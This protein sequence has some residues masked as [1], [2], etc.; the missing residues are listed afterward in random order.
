M[1]C[2]MEKSLVSIIVPV[3]NTAE[4]VEEC[5][6]SVLSQSYKNIELILVNDGS[7]DGSGEICK[8]YED[9][10]NVHY[11]EKENA[12]VVEA[13]K[14]GL[15]EAH[16]EWIMFVD[17]DDYILKNCVDELYALTDDVD[18]VVGCNTN[19]EKLKDAPKY[20]KRE[21]YLYALYCRKVPFAP[22][23]KLI[24][25]E[26]FDHC[27]MTFVYKVP[28]EEDYIMNLALARVNKK[29]VAVWKKPVYFY[30]E[31]RESATHSFS[32]ELDYCYNLCH[33]IESILGGHM[34]EKDLNH[35]KILIRLNYYQKYLKLHGMH[36]NKNHPLVKDIVRLM[37]KEKSIRLSDRLILY[38]SDRRAMNFCFFLRKFIIRIEHPSLVI[39]DFKRYWK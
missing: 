16:G 39:R 25:K 6:Q 32:Y 31:R 1:N 17:S 7:T 27:H 28:I 36:G 34:S 23:A 22:W 21:A 10:P 20:F 33:I 19:N 29:K 15:E 35:G 13:R 38:V 2:D 9:L 26:L 18:I 37:N 4:Y 11:I 24:R 12:G 14:R 3:Y 5:I 30:R 8:K